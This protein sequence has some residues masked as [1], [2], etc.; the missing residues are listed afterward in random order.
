[1]ALFREKDNTMVVSSNFFKTQ[2]PVGQESKQN[3]VIDVGGQQFHAA[4]V[5]LI[6][7]FQH[8]PHINGGVIK[9]FLSRFSQCF[10]QFF[11][12][13]NHS[14]LTPKEHLKKLLHIPITELVG[15][16]ADVLKQ[17]AVD[18]LLANALD[19]TYRPVFEHL[20]SETPKS[21]L[22]DPRTPLPMCALKAMAKN[23]GLPLVLSFK[24]PPAKGLGKQEKSGDFDQSAL[25][26]QIQ[27]DA[28]YPVVNHKEGF[29][30]GLF[31]TA[32]LIAV[33]VSEE[34]DTMGEI[35]QSIKEDNLKRLHSYEQQVHTILAMIKAKE[36]DHQQML[37]F[38]ITL[39][40]NQGTDAALFIRKLAQGTQP[41]IVRNVIDTEQHTFDLAHALASWI[42]ADLIKKEQLFD[43]IDNLPSPSLGHS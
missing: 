20:T 28:Y 39:L 33:P 17:L 35:L 12:E 15:R 13:N 21:Y 34:K 7:Y 42:A 3:E 43:Q 25:V 14:L 1:M 2:Q 23:L 26:I 4:A 18:E 19:L 5:A 41:L 10:P 24:E 40:P 27:G 31:S 22:R 36:L 11:S 32:S 38:Y 8:A 37:N 30:K 6:N 29:Q 16:V 9:K